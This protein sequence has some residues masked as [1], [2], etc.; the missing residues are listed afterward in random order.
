M[1]QS[2]NARPEGA[3]I[4]AVLRWKDPAA[5]LRALHLQEGDIVDIGREVGNDLVLTDKRISR[6]HAVVAYREG[7]FEV[8]DLGSRNG[9]RVNDD[10]IAHPRRLADGDVI[11]L[12]DTQITFYERGEEAPQLEEEKDTT[13][14]FIVRPD[15]SQPRLIVT[16]GNQDG[17]EFPLH[18]EKVNLGRATAKAD[19]D[20]A[21]QDRAISRPHL[22]I[23]H[24]ESQYILTDLDSA[25]GT[26][27]NG[28]PVTEPVPLEDGDVIVVGETT[29][30]FQSK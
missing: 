12:E 18:A 11:R 9:T 25:N 23:E 7:G 3:S 30:L 1:F 24:K 20:I 5:G 6:K 13:H 22:E 8:K 27:V 14:T 28:N 19:W 29:L 10:P 4:L 26:Q 17:R 2:D 21:L 16:A 15:V